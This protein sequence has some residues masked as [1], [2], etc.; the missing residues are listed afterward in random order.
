MAQ[1]RWGEGADNGAGVAAAGRRGSSAAQVLPK[2]VVAATVASNAA[3]AMP[4]RCRRMV[5]RFMAVPLSGRA[6]ESDSGPSVGSGGVSAL[7]LRYQP[8]I[9]PV[10]RFCLDSDTRKVRLQLL[11]P[12]E[13]E[14]EGPG[15]LGPRDRVVLSALALRIGRPL[16]AEELAD[17]LWGDHPPTSWV[18]VVQGC[19]SRLRRALGP[20]AIATMPAG[21]RLDPSVVQLDR[22]DFD[23][24]V[25]RARDRT[26]SGSP[27]RA[28]SLLDEALALWRGSPFDAL[29]EWEPGR[30]EVA[31]LVESRRTAE[32]DL[33]EARLDS[34]GHRQ[35]AEEGTVLVGEQPWRERR[36]AM[37]AL[38]QY[39][40]G[41]QADALATIRS[42]R[43]VLDR[44]LG[45]D[46]GSGLVELERRILDHDPSLAPEHRA[47]LAAL[48]CPW[49]GLAPYRAEDQ[50]FFH[51]RGAEVE[52]LVDRLDRTALLVLAGSSGGG[53][54]SLMNAGLGP[55]LGRRGRNWVGFS[56]GTNGPAAMVVALAGAG[57]K[58]VLLIDQFEE[59]FTLGDPGSAAAWMADL[60]SYALTRAPV[61]VTVRADQ[62]AH[63]TLDVDFARLAQGGLH[64]VAPLTGADLRRVIEAPAKLAGLRLE[65]GL[66][67]LLMRDAEDQPGALP[68]LSH[69]L[70]QAWQRR[71]DGLLTV[72]GYLGSGGIR[73]AVAASADRLYQSLS[74][75]Q[76]EQLHALLL[77]MVM[78][79]DNDEPV[80]TGLPHATVGEEWRP[81]VD[82]LVRARLVTSGADKLPDRP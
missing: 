66:V 21:Y 68:L 19:I 75:R 69:A 39:R 25:A 47:R 79:G 10:D 23:D 1:V 76:R 28:A 20:D 26:A 40:C 22:D 65:Q 31:R 27:E 61:V 55:A 5:V 35:V 80:R 54:S 58:P 18:K 50:D 63:L 51:G 32:E 56:P 52:A 57:R 7:P 82:L 71:V 49:K 8:G 73:G 11:G 33:L 36:W 14:R 24:L 81:V 3:A 53:K 29:E 64:L 16:T 74:P 43:R 78:L 62:L 34:G 4:V 13:L 70:T 67:D 37:L 41:R 60:A 46:P 12:L 30:L 72:D 42:A 38:A 48:A 59:T 45:L 2:V 15:S 9:S 77:R 44:E 17:A 6:G